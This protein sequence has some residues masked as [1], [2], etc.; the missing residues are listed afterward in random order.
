VLPLFLLAPAFAEDALPPIVLLH[1]D[2]A[3]FPLLTARTVT[4]PAH[5]PT[6]TWLIGF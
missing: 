1:L 4:N 5:R 2:P 6:G 3:A